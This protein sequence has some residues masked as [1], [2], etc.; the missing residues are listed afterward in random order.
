MFEG[1]V[2]YLNRQ[3]SRLHEYNHRIRKKFQVLKKQQHRKHHHYD[4]DKQFSRSIKV[5]SLN[6]LSISFPTWLDD[7]FLSGFFNVFKIFETPC[8]E[9][10][11]S[12]LYLNGSCI[13]PHNLKKLNWINIFQ[14]QNIESLYLRKMIYVESFFENVSKLWSY[15]LIYPKWKIVGAINHFLYA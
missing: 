12:K 8:D 6:T 15:K 13:Y 2:E 14:S 3:I 11:L 4:M 1:I 9:L 7:D 5:L 10:R